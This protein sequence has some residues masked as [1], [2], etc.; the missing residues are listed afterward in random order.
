[1]RNNNV[2][3]YKSLTDLGSYLCRL[4]L[5]VSGNLW[6]LSF[7][8]PAIFLW[9]LIAL[10]LSVRHWAAEAAHCCYPDRTAVAAA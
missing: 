6:G 2:I 10:V 7:F 8:G 1:M 3:C 4:F 9:I 5:A